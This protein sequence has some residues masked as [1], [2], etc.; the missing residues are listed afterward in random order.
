MTPP[1]DNLAMPP[2][3]SDIHWMS[4]ALSWAEKAMY[5]TTPNPRV[6][7]VIVNAQGVLLGAGHTQPA[8]QAHAEIMAIQDAKQQGHSVA[9]ATAYVTLEPCSHQGRTGPCCDALIQTGLARLVVA[10]Q[11]PN[12][13]VSGNG[14]A[15]LRQAGIKVDVGIL[16]DK[17]RSLNLGFFK[18][19]TQGVPW[20]RLKVAASLDGQTALSNGASQWITSAAARQDGHAW[21][22]RACAVLTGIGTLLEDDPQLNV[23]DVDTP[24]QPALVI[25]DS[26]LETPLNAKLWQSQREVWIYCAKEDADRK[27]ALEAKGA[28]VT[29]LPNAQGKVDLRAMHKDLGQRSINEVHIEA[30]FKLNGSLLGVGVVDEL[31]V[32]L[33]PLLIGQGLG[34]ANLGPF[35]SLSQALKLDIQNITPIG[36]DVRL[37]AHVKGR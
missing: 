26:K 15:R 16:E 13:Q 18:R 11:D 37:I 31:L 28:H 2:I 4:L 30:G 25:V 10:D 14:I 27:T 7:C 24:R 19:M 17:A 32:Y 5:I 3:D 6:G 1:L 29:C 21:R 8:G 20:M 34:L 12:P 22:A 35:E 23:R 36:D 33:A 9:G